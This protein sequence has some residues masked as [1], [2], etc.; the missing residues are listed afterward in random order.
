MN[1]SLVLK[2]AQIRH[3]H[4]SD[5][6]NNRDINCDLLLNIE[7]NDLE[8]IAAYWKIRNGNTFFIIA[9]LVFSSS[10]K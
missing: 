4:S 2:R 6:R 9:V 10:L 7:V 1:L 5:K 3:T 8:K